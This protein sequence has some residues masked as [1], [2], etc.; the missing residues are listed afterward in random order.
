MIARMTGDSE[1]E[2]TA[3]LVVEL[4]AMSGED[5]ERLPARDLPSAD[6]GQRS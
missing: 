1:D 5:A 3:R 4:E 6:R 2:D